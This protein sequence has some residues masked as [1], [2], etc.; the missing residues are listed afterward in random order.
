MIR[1]SLDDLDALLAVASEGSFTRAAAK[2]GM[3][4]SALSQRVRNFEERLGLRMLARTTRRVAPTEAGERLLREAGPR[5]AEVRGILEDLSSLRETPSGTIRITSDEFALETVVW[6]VLRKFLPQ[7]PEVTVEPVIDYG[8]T[9]IV[10]ERYDAGIRLGDVIAKDMVTVPI[11]GDQRMVV[12]A[13][14]AHLQRVGIPSHPKELLA[15]QCLNVRLPTGGSPYAW[16]FEKDGHDLKLRVDGPLICNNLRV[17]LDA[18]LNGLGFA[19]LPE[20]LVRSH[21]DA[22]DLEIVL[23]DWSP[24]YAGYR[25]YY[26]NRRQPSAAFKLLVE[27]LRWRS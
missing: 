22:K 3:T 14:P 1:E 19:Y 23:S 12:V 4:Q 25:L 21:V 6:P 11:T 24:Y 2:L 17:I 18:V 27:A 16:E 20:G 26:P 8:L 13:P 5:L 9:D 7:Y 10:A 15:R